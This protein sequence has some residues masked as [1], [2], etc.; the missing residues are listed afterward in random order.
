MT[1]TVACVYASLTRQYGTL[2]SVLY[3]VRNV[4]CMHYTCVPAHF[5][6]SDND[7]ADEN[8]YTHVPLN[9]IKAE[10]V[11]LSE[12]EPHN[13]ALIESGRIQSYSISEWR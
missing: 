1:Y 3:L 8:Q 4:F 6:A 11:F 12:F 13:P 7:S 5:P 9:M 2:S 10:R